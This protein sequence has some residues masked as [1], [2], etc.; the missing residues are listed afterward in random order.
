M[1]QIDG[2]QRKV[3]IKF[4][5]TERMM[6]VF[7]SVKGQFEFHHENGELSL[8]EVER[9]GLGVKR[10]RIVNLPP[11]VQVGTLRDALTKY[12]EVPR[13]TEEQWAR[14][15]RYPVRNGV[16][17]VE[18][19]LQKHIPSHMNILQKRILVSYEGQPL[20]C[21]GCNEPGHPYQECPNKTIKAN[22]R[23]VT[24]RN[25]WPQVVTN[26]AARRETTEE[27][28]TENGSMFNNSA[29]E[30]EEERSPT[31]R[32]EEQQGDTAMKHAL[33][34]SFTCEKNQ[35]TEDESD[36]TCDIRMM[37]DITR[38]RKEL[39]Y[40]DTEKD[41]VSKPSS[42]P[43]IDRDID[44]IGRKRDNPN[45]TNAEE[46]AGKEDEES[47]SAEAMMKEPQT[48]SPTRNKKIKMDGDQTTP[49]ERKRSKTMPKAPQR[50]QMETRTDILHSLNAAH[51][52]NCNPQHQWDRV[53]YENEH[54]W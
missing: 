47:G 3:Y 50:T 32:R 2:T 52:Q 39:D 4:V 33:A 5:N 38:G 15:Y 24:D 8:V 30:K 21:Y 45:Q 25:T 43:V 16:R 34:S 44:K 18:I 17:I 23:T 49:R 28:P 51:I 37:I 54:A 40:N 19:T 14:I 10:V 48:L 7:Q 31:G 20:T 13:I 11:E 29:E 46:Q 36:R 1:I 27:K 6:A 42:E 9:A 53:Q 22:N 41:Q 35:Y 12:G 26:E